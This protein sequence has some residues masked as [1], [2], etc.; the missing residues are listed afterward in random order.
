MVLF[1]G[2]TAANQLVLVEGGRD[3]AQGSCNPWGVILAC[4][5]VIVPTLAMWLDMNMPHRYT[6]IYS[7]IN[8]ICE[9]CPLYYNDGSRVKPNG[10]VAYYALWD[11]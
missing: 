9:P 3:H 5:G 4:F 7:L 8:V 1:I 6:L 2:L 10:Y 11:F